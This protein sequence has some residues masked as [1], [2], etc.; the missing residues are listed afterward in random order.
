MDDPKA[1]PK[2]VAAVFKEALLAE[3]TKQLETLAAQ[4]VESTM[5]RLQ[6][7]Q[8]LANI[9]VTIYPLRPGPTGKEH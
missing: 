9:V 2:H 5:E 7:L 4:P 3:C 1:K 6:Q 8:V